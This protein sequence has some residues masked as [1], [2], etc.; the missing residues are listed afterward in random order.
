MSLFNCVSIMGVGLIGGSLALAM[1][2]HGLCKTVVGYSRHEVNL[3]KALDCG[4]IDEYTLDAALAVKHADLIVMAT[5]LSAMLE[6]FRAIHDKLLPGALITDVGSAKAGVLRAASLAFGRV[7]DTFVP[8]HP[9]AGT[10]NSGVD[11]AF[12]ELFVN[13]RVVL[14]PLPT[15][16]SHAV[17]K[18]RTLWEKVGA[19]VRE[20]SV[21]H[22]DELLAATSHL[23]HV[24]AYTLVEL[25]AG[26]SEQEAV[27]DY[28]AGGFRDFSRIASSDPTMWRDICVDNSHA[29]IS[30]IERYETKL[31]I[32]KQAIEARDGAKLL[33]IFTRAK[34]TRDHHIKNLG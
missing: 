7:P 14:T 11:A 21:E 6:I 25:L 34:T 1:R 33:E 8:G 9:I 24:L 13:R 18:I 12:A 26:F 16:S 20:T 32:V 15:T 19:K 29:L 28:A 5:P 3:K 23:P 22:H 31:H 17:A 10:E 30:I 2:R 27:F 4:A